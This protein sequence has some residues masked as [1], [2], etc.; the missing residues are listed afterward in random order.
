M[1]IFQA[2]SRARENP[3][4]RNDGPGCHGFSFE[5]MVLSFGFPLGFDP[6]SGSWGLLFPFRGLDFFPRRRAP[7]VSHT[8]KVGQRFGS[9]RRLGVP[10]SNKAIGVG[11]DEAL[12]IVCKREAKPAHD[13]RIEHFAGETAGFDQTSSRSPPRASVWLAVTSAPLFSRQMFPRQGSGGW[14]VSVNWF[15]VLVL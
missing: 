6:C 14:S 8:F 3:D 1:S 12:P 5:P 13:L 11:A 7:E 10:N 15:C 2:A 9:L 4:G